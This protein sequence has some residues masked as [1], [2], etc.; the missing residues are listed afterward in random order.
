MNNIETFTLI[1]G[2]FTYQDAREVLVSLFLAKIQFHEIQNF[3]SQERFGKEDEMAVK[4]IPDLKK[5]LKSVLEL[6]SQAAEG[7]KK[8]IVNSVINIEF[9][10]AD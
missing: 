7:N 3:S 8:M 4:R 2:H 5:N 9:A 10:D 6:V 1:D